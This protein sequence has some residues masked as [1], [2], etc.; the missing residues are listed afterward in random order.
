[1]IHNHEVPSSILGLATRKY[2]KALYF[3]FIYMHQ[4]LPRRGWILVFM[5]LKACFQSDRND[6]GQMWAKRTKAWCCPKWKDHSV[7]LANFLGYNATGQKGLEGA[8]RGEWN[9][10]GLA[11]RKYSKALYFFR[12]YTL[13]SSGLLLAVAPKSLRINNIHDLRCVKKEAAEKGGQIITLWE[14]HN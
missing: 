13:S 1:M 8:A 9:I 3:F 14:S 4:A 7:S 11:T 12:L 5:A 10:L 2:S 6:N